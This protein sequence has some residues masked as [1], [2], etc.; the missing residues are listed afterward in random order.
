MLLPATRTCLCL[1]LA[2]LAGAAGLSLTRAPRPAHALAPLPLPAPVQPLTS[3]PGDVLVVGDS[4]AVGTRPYLDRMLAGRTLV[5]DARAGRTTPQGIL[6][7]RVALRHVRPRTFVISL[8][9]NDGSDARRFASRLRR[10]MA[11]LPSDACVVWST[12]VRPPRKGPY[13]GLNRVL[14]REQ[15]RDRRLVLVDWEAAV[16]RGAVLLP[17]GLHADAT[18]YRTRSAMIADAVRDTCAARR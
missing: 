18:G 12:V 6:A 8:G 7:L 4:L 2:L 1:S 17:D 16:R 14:R 13:H 15:R 10:L 11:S 5:W 9:T 3:S